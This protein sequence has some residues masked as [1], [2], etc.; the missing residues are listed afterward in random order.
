MWNRNRD[1]FEIMDP[2]TADPDKF[3]HGPKEPA[4]GPKKEILSIAVERKHASRLKPRGIIVAPVIASPESVPEPAEGGALSGRQVDANTPPG[5]PTHVTEHHTYLACSAAVC[6][7]YSGQRR[8]QAACYLR[9]GGRS[10]ARCPGPGCR[11]RIRT[12][13]RSSHSRSHINRG[14]SKRTDYRDPGRPQ[15]FPRRPVAEGGAADQP[16]SQGPEEPGR[17]GEPDSRG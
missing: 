3:L 1:V 6:S 4:P 12:L 11:A 16:G 5:S 2:R 15:G 14:R 7:H 17:G 8:N 13:T 10:S 9:R